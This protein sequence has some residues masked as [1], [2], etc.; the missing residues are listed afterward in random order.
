[1]TTSVPTHGQAR[2]ASAASAVGSLVEWYDFALYGAAAAIVFNTHFFNSDSPTT[3]LLASFATFAVGY[4]ARPLGGVLFGHLGDKVGRKPVM[5]FTLGLMGIS[6]T[7]IGLLPTYGAIGITAPVLLMVL[8]VLQGLGAGAE[9]AGAITLSAESSPPTHRGFYASWSGAGVWVGSA[10]GVGSFQLCLWLTG[11]SFETWGWRVPFLVSLVMLAISFY[12]RRSVNETDSFEK[13]KDSE[14]IESQPLVSL[15]RTDKGRLAVA[16]GSN[17]MLSGFSYVPQVWA[18]SYLTNDLAVAAGASLAIQSTMLVIG[19]VSMPFFG[20]LGDLVGRRRLFL[21]G[22]CF[23]IVW[24]FPMFMLI[25]TGNTALIILALSVCFVG[26][27]ATCY[28]AQAA[29]L[30]ELFPPAKRYSGVAF[31]REVSGAL[32][33]GTA[34]LAATAMVAWADSWWPVAV[35]MVGMAVISLISVLASRIYRSDEHQGDVDRFNHIESAPD[36]S[37][38]ATAGVTR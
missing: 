14:A 19:A 18:L 24:A 38:T 33:G 3:G 1:M 30:T 26:A 5:I 23:G 12:I 32:L 31:A 7:L 35:W 11:D 13:A 29:F 21:F 15:L 27:V 10:M 17:L 22:C 6:T 20:R 28:A 9:Y 8:R 16:L 25:D 36:P 4:F 2:R 37:G 34:P